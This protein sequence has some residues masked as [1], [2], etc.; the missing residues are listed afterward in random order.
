M[1]FFST[2]DLEVINKLN[3]ISKKGGYILIGLSTSVPGCIT[4]SYI[5]SYY[6]YGY[7]PVTIK[8]LLKTILHCR[9]YRD[10]NEALNNIHTRYYGRP[11]PNNM[12][13]TKYI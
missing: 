4:F 2:N 8:N 9:E 10:I 6:D 3:I 12:P 5:K 13:I 7:R 1:V 11:V